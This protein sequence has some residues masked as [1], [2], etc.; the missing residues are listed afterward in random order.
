MNRNAPLAGLGAPVDLLRKICRKFGDGEAEGMLEGALTGR[1]G[2]RNDL[3]D[4][5]HEVGARPTGTSRARAL[6]QLQTH[7]PEL[8]A[9][10]LAGRIS[11]HAACL[12]AG[13]R[14]P[15]DAFRTAQRL[16]AKMIPEERDAV[17]DFIANWRRPPQSRPARSPP[18][19]GQTYGR[20][21]PG[22]A[23]GGAAEG[24]CRERS[25]A[26]NCI[27]SFQPW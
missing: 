11:P 9:E 26:W 13:L 19:D 3:V 25:A 7:A 10:V 12:K 23:P 18:T 27:K 6:R 20:R 5:I 2:E 22:T 17:E 4:N 14:R 24:G 16:W 1:Q 21:A 8:H 15:P